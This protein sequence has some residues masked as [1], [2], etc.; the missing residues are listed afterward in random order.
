[1][2]VPPTHPPVPPPYLS[3]YTPLLTHPPTHPPSPTVGKQRAL[4]AVLYISHHEVRPTHPP[5]S[6]LSLSPPTYPTP[7]SQELIQ[8]ASFSSINSTHPPTYP[9]QWTAQYLSPHHGRIYLITLLRNAG[10]EDSLLQAAA[11]AA[12]AL[13]TQQQQQVGGWVVE[14][15]DR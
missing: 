10:V 15:V 7:S 5:T 8:T 1:M 9:I 11:I 6:F 3:I 4:D 14:W 13:P 12:A 2:N